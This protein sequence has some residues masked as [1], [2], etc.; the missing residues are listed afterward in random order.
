[1]AERKPAARRTAAKEDEGAVY[2]L[3]HL[4]SGH[5]PGDR[6]DQDL[7]EQDVDVLLREGSASRD[8]PE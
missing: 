8:K 1:M 6:I 7:R 5:R 3:V 4:T 2:S